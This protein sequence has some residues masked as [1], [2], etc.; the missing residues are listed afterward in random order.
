MKQLI[1]DSV[2]R[3][4]QKFGDNITDSKSFDVYVKS[5]QQV[6]ESEISSHS[7]FMAEE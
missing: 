1:K 7:K 3:F 6:L 2:H 5:K 4:E